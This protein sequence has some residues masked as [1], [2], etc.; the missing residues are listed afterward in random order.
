MRARDR[1][2]WDELV[3]KE[4]VDKSTET[5]AYKKWKNGKAHLCHVNF[6]SAR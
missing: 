1:F 3:D 2:V 6:P 4:L 5:M